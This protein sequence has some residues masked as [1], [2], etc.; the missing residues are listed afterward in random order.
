RVSDDDQFGPG[1]AETLDL[2][3]LLYP[4]HLVAA[5]LDQG[6]DLEPLV[7]EAHGG[8]TRREMDHVPPLALLPF[9]PRPASPESAP[10]RAGGLAQPYEIGPA[11]GAVERRARDAVDAAHS[12]PTLARN[13]RPLDASRRD[14]RRGHVHAVAV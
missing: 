6:P 12:R 9:R 11:R 5:A 3:R 2:I 8:V 14:G 10:H 4:P 7:E 1:M 13:A